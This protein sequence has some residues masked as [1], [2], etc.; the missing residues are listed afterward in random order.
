MKKDNSK[1]NSLEGFTILYNENSSMYARGNTVKRHIG[2]LTQAI[3]NQGFAVE[4]NEFP[5]NTS[6][7]YAY[8]WLKENLPSLKNRL[9]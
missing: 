8:D 1:N 7:E 6:C 9:L 4:I 2:E 3:I 5:E